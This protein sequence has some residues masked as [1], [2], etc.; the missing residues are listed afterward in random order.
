[1]NR[2]YVAWHKLKSEIER[3]KVAPLFAER[4]VWWCS[5]G[6]NIGAEED[7]KN[8]LFERPVLIIKKFSKDLFWGLPMSSRVK[9]GRFYFTLDVDG[10]ERSVM[11]SQ[12][13]VLSAYRLVRRIYKIRQAHFGQVLEQWGS[14]TQKTD[15]ALRRNPRVPSGNLYSN[16]SKHSVES[17]QEED[18][19]IKGEK[20]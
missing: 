17:Q 16:N 15:S 19:K 9:S 12:I 10:T 7:G 1:M 5:L 3:R 13:R 6:A 4:E 11:L 18:S 20:T 2:N 14:M 8:E